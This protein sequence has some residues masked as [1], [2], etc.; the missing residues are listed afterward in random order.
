MNAICSE[1]EVTLISVLTGIIMNTVVL[2]DRHF[3]TN[4]LT[5]TMSSY[6]PLFKRAGFLC[7]EALL[8]FG[9]E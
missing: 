2:S 5:V 8:T 4:L 7:S 6:F 3:L 1:D 9:T